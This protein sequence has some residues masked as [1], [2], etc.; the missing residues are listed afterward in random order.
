VALVNVGSTAHYSI[1]YD[2]TL[3]QADGLTRAQQLLGVCEQDYQLM[4]S[5]FP[6]L[7]L[8]FT[9]PVPSISYPAVMR[10]RAGG[11]RS[12]YGRVMGRP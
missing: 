2:G 10:A 3:S 8:P 7:S 4:A 11:R 5:W 9:L 6:G 1:S 12:P